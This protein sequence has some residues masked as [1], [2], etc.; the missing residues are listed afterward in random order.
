MDYYNEIK[1]ELV[2]NEIYKKVKDYSKNKNELTTYYNVGKLL[3]DAQGGEE[4][5]KYGDNLIKE[6]SIRLTN[7]LGKGYTTSALKRMRLFYTLVDKG[8]PVAHQLTWS[9]Y[10]ELLKI[11]NFNIINYYVNISIKQNLSVRQL[12]E[13]IKN[14]EYERLDEDTRNKLIINNDDNNQIKDF[15]K[16]QIL[17]KNTFNYQEISEKL[18]KQLILEDVSSFMKEI[19]EELGKIT[20]ETVTE[21]VIKEIF[22]KFC[23]GK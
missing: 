22:S 18:L 15:I 19:L 10:I 2:N 9:H 1:N 5:A 11:D 3:I 4:R 6:Y 16:H 17:I 13:K 20:G 7:E 8:A 14:N 23:L 12:R 21:D